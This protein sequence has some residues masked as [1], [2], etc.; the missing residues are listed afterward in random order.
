[1]QNTAQ[2]PFVRL[3][4][5]EFLNTV[6]ALH[7][8]IAVFDCDGTLW[9][10]DAGSAFM[11]WSTETG[12]LSRDASDW[13]DTRYRA[14][15]HDNVSEVAMCGEMVQVYRGLREAE[16]RTAAQAFFS[17]YIQPRIFPVMQQLCAD[18]KAMGTTLWAVSSTNDWV[19]E[20]AVEHFGIPAERVL[21]ARVRSVEG[22]V[23]DELI[24][25]PTDE[26]KAIALGRNGIMHPDA[27]FGNSIHDAAMLALAKHPF[28]I[29]PSEELRVLAAVNG[30]AIFQPDP[31]RQA[32]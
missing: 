4:A 15:L 9:S 32:R 30:W 10:G 21:C 2:S 20:A 17:L 24:D 5:P 22:I 27:V 3:S 8:S 31:T 16:L 14:Y 25:V 1:M 18:L 7:P 11:Q 6:R 13:L 12:L 19:I 28:A 29:N 26:G 23:T